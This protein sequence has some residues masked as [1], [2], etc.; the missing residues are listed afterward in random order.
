[1]AKSYLMKIT[2]DEDITGQTYD[3]LIDTLEK[4][5]FEYDLIEVYED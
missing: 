1:M 3:D 2:I 5:E 4:G